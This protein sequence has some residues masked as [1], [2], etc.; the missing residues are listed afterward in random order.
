LDHINPIF[1]SGA[2]ESGF[3][4][5]IKLPG[6]EPAGGRR[7]RDA[8]GDSQHGEEQERGDVVRCECRFVDQRPDILL[9]SAIPF[10]SPHLTDV[11]VGKVDS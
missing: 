11:D 4:H 3:R 5:P 8:S 7:R 1:C 9:S 2:M 6:I 10:H